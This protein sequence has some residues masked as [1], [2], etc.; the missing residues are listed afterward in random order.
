MTVT[1]IQP[2]NSDGKPTPMCTFDADSLRSGHAFEAMTLFYR[3]QD[4]VTTQEERIA[5][6]RCGAVLA[7]QD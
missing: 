1:I 3:V 2:K 6:R 7:V 4:G 5:C